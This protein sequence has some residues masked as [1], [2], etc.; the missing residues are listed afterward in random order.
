MINKCNLN[1]KNIRLETKNLILRPYKKSDAK[2]LVENYNSKI[3]SKNIIGM[4]YPYLLKNAYQF[5]DYTENAFNRA[6]PIFELAVFFKKENRVI[7]GVA[8]KDIDLI[9]RNAE[10]ASCIAKN[11]WGTKLIYEAKL[12]LY[13]FAFKDLK[14][15]KI[16]SEVL[17]NNIRSEL[18]LEK[19]G[20][21]QQGYFQKNIF[22]NNKFI[23]VYYLELLKEN[24]KYRKLK[25]KLF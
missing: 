20:F 5:I 12:E 3:F 6:K 21:T 14:L 15:I 18:H 17:V 23:D 24:F 19:L 16:Y 9:N 4:P 22:F 10:S 2:F 25:E 1:L 13:K 11:Y 8:L 7:G